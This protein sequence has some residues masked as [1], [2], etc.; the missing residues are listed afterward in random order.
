MALG[1]RLRNDV[2]ALAPDM[3][4]LRHRLHR[5][6]ETGLRLPWTQEQLLSELDGLG[7]EV[8]VGE[9]LSSITAVLRGEKESAAGRRPAVLLRADMDAL[10]VSEA[11]GVDFASQIDDVMH[12][13]GHDLHMA[14]L[15]G[16]ARVLCAH[17]DELPGD[18]V[19]MLQPGEEGWDGAR[20]MIEE[21]VLD[22]SGTRVSSAYGMHVVAATYP[23]RVFSGR[24]GA[25]MAASDKLTVTVHGAGAHGST[26]HLGR[27]PISAIAEIVGS[28]HA[29]VTRRFDVFDPVV[30]TVG[31]LHG[32]TKHNII[33]DEARFEA[34]IRTFSRENRELMKTQLPMLCESVG[35]AHGV[36]VEAIHHS[37][38]P[39]TINDAAEVA[40]VADT[41]ADVF[42]TG[43]YK[44]M[45]HP[46]T[47]AEDF[48]RVLDEVPG[49]Y[50]FLGASTH[51]DPK[52]APSNHSP[53]ATF[54][55]DVLPLGAL[56]HTE[57]ATRA[58]QRHAA[59]E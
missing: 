5:H 31:S 48:S 45:D 41:V 7:M 21:G 12:A 13:C 9:S 23:S 33:P 47:G 20:H 49:A 25:F 19:F 26:P 16:A 4:E 8:T 55:D 38:Y 56:L 2:E 50:V 34:T 32:G 58:L 30:L 59:P 53:R 10:P 27:D 11:T 54:S 36:Q 37:E 6:P 28:L 57:L 43:A 1:D 24:A 46:D 14:M 39:S 3:T 51:A 29:F 35:Q 40:F 18:V 15:I 17:R 42:G 22:A 52:T 44:L